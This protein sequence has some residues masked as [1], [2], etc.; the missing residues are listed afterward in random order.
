LLFGCGF[1]RWDFLSFFAG[2]SSVA[3]WSFPSLASHPTQSD[4]LLAADLHSIRKTITYRQ[5]A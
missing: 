2:N 5:V 1:P 3:F 4:R